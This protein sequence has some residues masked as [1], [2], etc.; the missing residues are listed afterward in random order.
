MSKI[1]VAI[2]GV[3]NCTSSF[4]QGLEFYKKNNTDIGLINNKIGGYSISDIEVV[5]AFD[6]NE[7]K[8]GKDLSE[9][10]FASPNIAY[11]CPDIE[12]LN[13]GIEVKMGPVLD[14]NPPHLAEFVVAAKKDPVDVEKTLQ[15]SGAEILLN[16]LPTGS[17]KAARYYADVAIKKP[18]IGDDVK[19]Q[20]G[21]TII[22]RA[23][24]ELFKDRGIHITKM[25]QLNYAGNTD[26]CNLV[27]R[28]ESKM[29][30]KTEALTTA[31]PY[32][33]N[34]STGF[35]F[36]PNMGDRKTAIFKIEGQNYSG[37]PLLFE[38]KLE[39]EDSP[40]F[41]GVIADAVRYCKL[42]LDRGISGILTSACAFLA[43]HP[44]VQF[45]DKTAKEMLE[46][47]ITG[48]RKD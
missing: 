18:L 22:N 39:V 17:A 36:I 47:F 8:V 21:A 25:Y 19:S 11:K 32:E 44:P 13:L 28:G 23:L 9:A 5:A 35:S 33:A 42:A 14:G 6:I 2:V 15:G 29:K 27:N 26:F 38:A 34:V 30:T 16:F 31:I 41:G 48:K 46:Q 3:G 43:K 40:N 1:K 20:I 7:M 10:I 4:I 37:A 12:V 24:I 45:E